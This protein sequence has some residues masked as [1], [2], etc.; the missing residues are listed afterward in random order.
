MISFLE[1]LLSEVEEIVKKVSLLGKDFSLLYDLVEPD[2]NSP[3]NLM[4]LLENYREFLYK[5]KEFNHKNFL[6]AQD[7]Y[8]LGFVR[9]KDGSGKLKGITSQDGGELSEL[10]RWL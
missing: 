6:K 8:D 5:Q 3:Q 4:R 9:E 2:Q 10:L 7:F 1:P